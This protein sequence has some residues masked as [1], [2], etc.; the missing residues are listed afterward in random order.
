M[1]QDI[2]PKVYHNEYTPREI[3]PEDIVFVFRGREVLLREEEDGFRFPPA[4]KRRRMRSTCFLSM[5]GPSI[6][7]ANR[8]RAMS[9]SPCGCC[10]S[11]RL[12]ISALRA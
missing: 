3:R 2:Q 6:W 9:F 4:R 12:R 1:I 5:T 8:C 11:V 7:A 10:G